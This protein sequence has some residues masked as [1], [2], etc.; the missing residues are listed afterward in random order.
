MQTFTTDIWTPGL[1]ANSLSRK[2]GSVS[3]RPST[4]TSSKGASPKAEKKSSGGISGTMSAVFGGS[5]SD[6]RH[7]VSSASG[8]NGSN[9]NGASS[10]KSLRSSKSNISSVSQQG[11]H[12]QAPATN[13]AS[14]YSSG[15]GGGSSDG[16]A[17]K[18]HGILYRIFHP[19]DHEGQSILGRSRRSYHSGSES[20]MESE[21]EYASD[22]TAGSDM[23]GH[24]V[25]HGP[26]MTFPRS[27]KSVN[28]GKSGSHDGLNHPPEKSNT[29]RLMSMSVKK[30]A[31]TNDA[32]SA[33]ESESESFGGGIFRQT[34]SLGRSKGGNIFNKVLSGTRSRKSSTSGS[35]SIPGSR[36]NSPAN[37]EGNLSTGSGD[38]E[39]ETDVSKDDHSSHHVT[40][41]LFKNIMTS[42]KES[43]S[44]AAAAKA[45][46]E[47]KKNQARP[48]ISTPTSASPSRKASAASGGISDHS[49]GN[50]N[51]LKPPLPLP[52]PVS[53]SNPSGSSK[54]LLQHP[55]MSNLLHPQSAMESPVGV[56]PVSLSMA[57]LSSAAQIPRSAS[58][59]SLAEKYGKK[60]EILGKGANAVVR[61][62][63]PI[64]SDRKYAIKEFRKRRK[65][66]TQKEYVK[67]LVAE[68]CISSTLDH[69]N[70]VKTVDLI[71]DEKKKWCVV[72][73]YCAGGDLFGRIHSGTLTDPEEINCYFKQLA[74]GVQYLH[75]MGVAHRDLKPENLLLDV[76]GREI[77]ITDFGVSEVFRTPFGKNSTKAHGVCGSGPYIAPEEFV[78]KEY[79]SE[80][81]DLWAMGIIYY[82]MLYNSIPWKAASA[83]DARFKHYVEHHGAFWPLDR[84]PPGPRAAMYRIL[85]PNPAKRMTMSQLFENEWFKGVEMCLGK[86]PEECGHKHIRTPAEK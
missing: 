80:L 76:S 23:E 30:K 17:G 59:T 79:D 45:A 37:S 33:S 74:S 15:G 75:S 55:P 66:E 2:S 40:N 58:E 36:G 29:P 82:V 86:K 51:F 38:S 43:N 72:M 22:A 50:E 21:D 19:H 27:S 77:K 68:F 26:L 14:G 8:S 85:E 9:A 48:S 46:A 54:E 62:C 16:G 60:E 65:D 64:N 84:L 44:S 5:N 32:D 61:L 6:L 4:S 25:H 12:L 35:N 73:E 1:E 69:P 63:C 47:A 56:M 83:S 67:K 11:Q 41:K 24:H 31:S 71:Q 13:G 39:S 70:V 7:S 78:N 49:S 52:A 20:E 18:K 81:V 3:R 10:P 57:P 42:R 28:G 34:Q 53:T